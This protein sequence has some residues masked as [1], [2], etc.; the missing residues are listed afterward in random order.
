M[1]NFKPN[2]HVFLIYFSPIVYLSVCMQ[3]WCQ[4]NS[5]QKEELKVHNSEGI[6]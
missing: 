3:Q 6:L 5:H 1:V 4:S 2:L